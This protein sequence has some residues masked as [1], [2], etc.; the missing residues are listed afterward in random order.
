MRKEI[1]EKIDLSLSVFGRGVSI[2][3]V[4]FVAGWLYIN[5]DSIK[6]TAV[7]LSSLLQFEIKDRVNEPANLLGS[8]DVTPTGAVAEGARFIDAKEPLFWVYIGEM[9]WGQE[10]GWNSAANNFGITHKPQKNE[11][12]VTRV[13]VYKRSSRPLFK[14]QGWIMGEIL[15]ILRKNQPVVVHDVA[16]IHG[17]GGQGLW[18]AYVSLETL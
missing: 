4:I 13:D 15:G 3:A 12:I 6:I 10:D 2:A 8:Q 7:G 5:Q 1:L 11:R 14:E 18:W 16:E 9:S 17:V